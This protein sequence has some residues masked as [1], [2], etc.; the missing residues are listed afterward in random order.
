[1]TIAAS[2]PAYAHVN[3]DG[4]L[5]AANSKNIASSKVVTT[6]Y[7]CVVPSVAATNA[8]ASGDGGTVPRVYDGGFADPF[9]SCPDGAGVVESY[10]YS[11]GTF[12]H[13]NH[14]FYIVFN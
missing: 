10:V 1:M 13:A 9:T 6:G 11:G 8:V 14:D 12:S 4:T 2:V 3:A 7:Y 5:D